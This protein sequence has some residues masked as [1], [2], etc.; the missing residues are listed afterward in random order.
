MVEPPQQD[1]ITDFFRLTEDEWS[2]EG[3]RRWSAIALVAAAAERRVWVKTGKL[4][5]FLNLYTLLVAP[6]GTGKGIINVARRI[7]GEALEPGTSSQAFHIAPDSMTKAA[8]VDSLA[9]AKQTRLTPRGETYEYHSILLATEEFATFMPSYDGEMLGV[10]NNLWN[11]G[12]DFRE[13]RRHGPK[14]KIAIGYPVVNWL[15][16]IQPALMAMFPP[17]FWSTGL[18]RRTI[19]IYSAERKIRSPFAMGGDHSS[20]EQKVVTSLGELSTIQGEI[21]WEPDAEEFLHSWCLA[22]APP[23]PTHGKLSGYITSRIM[24]MIKLSGISVLSRGAKPRMITILDVKRAL[25]WL[26]T[27]EKVMPD[28][29]RAM[30]GRNDW[31]I[32]EEL[33]DFVISHERRF[34]DEP[35]KDGLIARF[36]GERLPSEKIRAVFDLAEKSGVVVRLAGTTLFRAG[37]KV[38]RR[39]E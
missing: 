19:M 3:F 27:V 4:V 37:A 38:L 26:L 1:V 39:P 8:F 30:I 15:A 23:E 31:E 9:E 5:T 13:N 28:I 35:L 22:G 32:I 16:G 11:N 6:P 21:G 24:H 25:E 12:V 36:L 10:L 17:E 14:P 33:H 34:K 18:G 7:M 29:F 20:L 2:P